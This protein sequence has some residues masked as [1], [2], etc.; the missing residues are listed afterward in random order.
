MTTVDFGQ[1]ISKQAIEK[2][3]EDVTF[4]LIEPGEYE[5]VVTG[6]ELKT[7][8]NG[9]DYINLEL[10]LDGGNRKQWLKLMFGISDEST[11]ITLKNI[12]TL[13]VDVTE[14]SK[15]EADPADIFIGKRAVARIETRPKYNDPDKE[16]NY[17]RWI[18]ESSLPA[19]EKTAVTGNAPSA[20][21]ASPF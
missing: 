20:A 9:N 5:V 19:V 16:E 12:R 17:V 4:K 3:E 15:V 1:L 2:L 13:G 11:A 18:N 10:T 7:S 6:A 8:A 21:P 14:L